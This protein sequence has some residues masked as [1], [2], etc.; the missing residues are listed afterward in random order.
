M[1]LDCFQSLLVRALRN[2]KG[3][4]SQSLGF[5]NFRGHHF[6][7]KRQRCP[8]W[9]WA[10]AKLG[11]TGH[12]WGPHWFSTS[13]A[14]RRV[15]TPRFGVTGA[16]T[17]KEPCPSW[18]RHG[19]H[20]DTETLQSPTRRAPNV[21][22]MPHATYIAGLRAQHVRDVQLRLCKEVLLPAR[23]PQKRPSDPRARG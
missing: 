15:G 2:T 8:Q 18:P 22:L 7:V 14:I 4:S 12:D 6:P 11:D 16:P 13:S 5:S 9:I 20:G 23:V 17:C 3:A 10:T 19:N 21:W 1:S